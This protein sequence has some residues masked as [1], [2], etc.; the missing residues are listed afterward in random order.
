MTNLK[1]VA[2]KQLKQ[3]TYPPH[4]QNALLKTNV[5]TRP[6]WKKRIKTDTI[7]RV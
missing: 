4:L 2:S 3:Y 5:Q 7:L 6:F 1:E